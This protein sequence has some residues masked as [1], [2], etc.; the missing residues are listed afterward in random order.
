MPKLTVKSRDS[1]HY[2]NI[3]IDQILLFYVTVTLAG[4]ALN[5]NFF[6]LLQL[7]ELYKLPDVDTTVSYDDNC[8]YKTQT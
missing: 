5:F 1:S 2:H 8:V 4:L 7:T 6:C 3:D